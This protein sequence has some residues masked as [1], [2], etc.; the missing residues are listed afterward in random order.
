ML[1]D[2]ADYLSDLYNLCD[3]ANYFTAAAA[4]VLR[5]LL[6]ADC[7]TS[8]LRQVLAL[9]EAFGAARLVDTCIGPTKLLFLCPPGCTNNPHLQ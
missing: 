8:D 2:T 7:G 4:M 9:P 6:A 5:V 3:L 1:E